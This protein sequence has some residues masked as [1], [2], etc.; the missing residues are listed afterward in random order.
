MDQRDILAKPTYLLAEFLRS[1]HALPLRLRVLTML[2]YS[3][4]VL[5]IQQ[6][7]G[8]LQEATRNSEAAARVRA[9]AADTM[10]MLN[11]ANEVFRHEIAP[12]L[13]DLGLRMA[14]AE[15]WT[16]R[17]RAWIGNL[18]VHQVRPLLTPLAVDAGRPFPQISAHSLNLLAVVQPPN[19][20]DVD[21]PSFARL[22]VPRWVPRLIELPH[23]DEPPVGANGHHPVRTF[24]LSEDMVR[25]HV[26]AIFP[27][28]PVTGVYQFRILRGSVQENGAVASRHAALAR[29]KAWPVVRIDVENDMPAWVLRWLQE[30]MEAQDAVVLRRPPPLGLGT[31]ASEWADRVTL[32]QSDQRKTSSPAAQFDRP[33]LPVP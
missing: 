16:P 20:F 25:L 15:G 21:M 14:P 10:Q 24:V 18:F 22:K 11:D 13:A 4:D 19:N 12:V 7:P 1:A 3:L 28:I 33:A 5:Y 2:T 8:L 23:L 6:L 26:D 9:V 30:N 31:L 27:G 17:Q 32:L 29:Q